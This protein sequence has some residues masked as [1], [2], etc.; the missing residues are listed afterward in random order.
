MAKK[1]KAVKESEA[2]TA[3]NVTIPYSVDL[4]AKVLFLPTLPIA[5]NGNVSFPCALKVVRAFASPEKERELDRE[6]SP[7]SSPIY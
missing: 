3:E 2:V 1:C 5:Q 7:T 6:N 4:L